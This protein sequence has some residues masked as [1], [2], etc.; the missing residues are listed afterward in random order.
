VNNLN[1]LSKNVFERKS[2]RD[3]SENISNYQ[4]D[5]SRFNINEKNKYEKKDSTKTECNRFSERI[6]KTKKNEE[7]LTNIEYENPLTTSLSKLN[8]IPSFY[9]KSKLIQRSADSSPTVERSEKS[10]TSPR[11]TIDLRNQ[12]KKLDKAF[13]VEVVDLNKQLDDRIEELE[14]QRRV[15]MKNNYLIKKDIKTV[16][17]AMNSTFLDNDLPQPMK[18]CRKNKKHSNE[19]ASNDDI[20]TDHKKKINSL[21]NK[22][23]NKLK[24]SVSRNFF[25]KFF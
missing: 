11:K 25:S 16:L 23:P 2:R 5:S 1:N 15:T 21:T 8:R 6:S 22:I 13:S 9:G 12:W 3:S 18:I 10:S 4:A 24:K 7:L 20:Q 19:Y 14:E 17:P